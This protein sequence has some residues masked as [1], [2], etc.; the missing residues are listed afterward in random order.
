MLP[1]RQKLNS[2]AILSM[3]GPFYVRLSVLLWQITV[4]SRV[5]RCVWQLIF[6]EKQISGAQSRIFWGRGDSWNEGTSINV[7]CATLKI[8]KM[9]LKL[10]IKLEFNLHKQG[11]F[12]QNQGTSLQNHCTFFY[13]QK[14]QRR[15]PPPLFP[16]SCEP[17]I[18]L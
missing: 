6:Y 10:H 4:R 1:E 8:L 5:D 9:L 7:S 11:K 3:L 13:F 18:S 15:P 2:F 16:T 14:E 17:E 12:F